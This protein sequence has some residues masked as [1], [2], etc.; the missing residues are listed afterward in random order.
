[1]RQALDEL[2]IDELRANALGLR[3]YKIACPWP[4]E[5]QG[6]R[7]FAQGLDKIIVVEEKRS[8]IENQLRDEL[9]GIA[10]QPVCVG[11]KDETGP[12]A[13]PGHRRARRQS[14]SPSRSAAA[15]S[16]S[17]ERRARSARRASRS[18]AARPRDAK[19]AAVRTPYFCSGCP[20]NTSTKVPDG[21]RAYA[22]IGCHYMVQRMDRATE[23]YT[24]MGGEGANWIGEAP[25]S[26][27]DHIIQNLGDGTYNH[28]GVLAMR[29]AIAAGNQ[30][31]LQ[32]PLQRCRRDDR[33]PAARRRADSR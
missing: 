18:A 20:H 13:V 14:T 26:T 25:F 8:L 2:G 6:L 29:W 1:M 19:D 4:L 15:C 7:E 12:L 30:H 33:R 16:T 32:D 31:H 10:H 21:M 28:S 9:Y 17:C 27:R 23:G 24:H 5:P 11:K 3:L 22:G